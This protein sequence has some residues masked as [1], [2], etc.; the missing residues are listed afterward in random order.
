MD[1]A[2]EILARLLTILRNKGFFHLYIRLSL[3]FQTVFLF[4]FGLFVCSFGW[5][6][7]VFLILYFKFLRSVKFS[8]LG[9]LS[10][11]RWMLQKVNNVYK[12]YQ[13][14]RML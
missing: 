13:D 12:S 3:K 11:D 7:G 2:C 8:Q 10:K 4:V 5:F 6:C 1:F 14:S 9:I